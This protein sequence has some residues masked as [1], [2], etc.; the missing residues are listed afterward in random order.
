MSNTLQKPPDGFREV[1]P[2]GG[3]N[4][5]LDL[6]EDLR[7]RRER[8]AVLVKAN[9]I[10][11]PTKLPPGIGKHAREQFAGPLREARGAYLELNRALESEECDP[12]KSGNVAMR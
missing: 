6:H 8:F 5:N 7:A 11:L 12:S 2:I 9:D 3:Q 10:P 1:A 4:S